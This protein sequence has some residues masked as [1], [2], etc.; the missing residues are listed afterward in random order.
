VGSLHKAIELVGRYQRYVLS[1][2]AADDDNLTIIGDLV[3]DGGKILTQAGVRGI[4]GH[5]SFS[6]NIVQDSCTWDPQALSSCAP[7]A[8]FERE[9]AGKRHAANR[10]GHGNGDMPV[11]IAHVGLDSRDQAVA[12]KPYDPEEQTEAHASGGE[13]E[14]GEKHANRRS[15]NARGSA[16]LMNGGQRVGRHDPL[17]YI[18]TSD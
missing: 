3:E 12:Y 1:S 10:D 18:V 6:S 5:I 15:E 8:D 17:G 11:G 14:R 4:D 7:S 9:S 2:T 13:D 16:A